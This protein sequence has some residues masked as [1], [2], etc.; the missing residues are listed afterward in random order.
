M[1]APFFDM[2]S[3][4]LIRRL[5]A[6]IL[7]ACATSVSVVAEESKQ[8]PRD[9]AEIQLSFAPVVK[10]AA[11]A[12]V[13]IYARQVQKAV[14][15][16]LFNDPFFRQFFGDQFGEPRERVRNALGSGVIVRADGLIVTNH[17]VVAD[18]NEIRVVLADRR[19]F[20]AKLVISDEKTD[21]AIL[22]I[23][24][25]GASL[26]VLAFRDSDELEVGDLVLAIGDPFGVG[27]TV[28]S[29]IISAL[30]RTQIGISDLGFFIQTDAAINPGNSGG[31]LIGMDGR[32]VGINTAIFSQSGGSIGIGFAIPSNMVRVIVAA[33]ESGGRIVRAWIGVT[34]QPVTP[35]LAR[36][37]GLERP[38][39]VVVNRVY[40]GGPADAA[41]LKPGDVI[42]AVNKREVLDPQSLN[43]R[44]ATMK[45][46]DKAEFEIW[47]K[48]QMEEADLQLAVAPEKP[49]RDETRLS[50][51]HPFDGAVVVNLSP[52]VAEE[53]SL[54][55]AWS[56]VAI[57]RVARGGV[58]A[59]IGFQ[60]GDIILS[61]NGREIRAVADLKPVLSR[62][63]D[64]WHISFRRNG[65]TETVTIR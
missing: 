16:S 62:Q 59:R 50:G 2:T 19:E 41:G 35:D 21:L 3:R 30:A 42:V 60:R 1:V 65:E 63:V 45:P 4:L 5:A 32:L 8:V 18:A 10:K 52:A 58:A 57:E 26:P 33:A 51:A 17:H 36:G 49:A 11:P 12:V 38:G 6:G 56:G 14:G 43:Y 54:E 24:S 28:T 40:Q 23:D 25:G 20:P 39:G 44:L 13:N 61:V 47:R 7:I 53:L 55:D 37:L 46:E 9:A 15:S 34:G 64:A 27:Q 29:G 31:A 22:R 48:G